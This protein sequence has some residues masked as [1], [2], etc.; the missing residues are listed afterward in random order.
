[1]QTIKDENRQN[2]EKG[3]FFP[4]SEISMKILDELIQE[5]RKEIFQNED[6]NGTKRT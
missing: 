3:I 1:M 6:T 5:A 2:Q 4:F